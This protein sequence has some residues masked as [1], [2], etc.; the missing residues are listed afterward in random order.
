MVLINNKFQEISALFEL[1]PVLFAE[2]KEQP[3]GKTQMNR[4][5]ANARFRYYSA[6]S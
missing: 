4:E 3:S 5:H 6:I 2:Y 1:L